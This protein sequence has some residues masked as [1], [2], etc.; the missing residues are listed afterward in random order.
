LVVDHKLSSD[1]S[2]IQLETC[3]SRSCRLVSGQTQRT[4]FCSIVEKK[5]DKITITEHKF[6]QIQQLLSQ[7]INLNAK[8][9]KRRGVEQQ[10]N[11]GLSRFR[12]KWSIQP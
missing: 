11:I 12:A 3:H 7:M 5:N 8:I 9:Q 2:S 4:W 10:K 1:V 6:L